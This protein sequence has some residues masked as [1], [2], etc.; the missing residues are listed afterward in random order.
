MHDLRSLTL[1]NA[2]E[3][4]RGEAEYVEHKFDGLSPQQ[5]EALITFLKSL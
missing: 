2:I 1:E 3:R 5:K 4:H